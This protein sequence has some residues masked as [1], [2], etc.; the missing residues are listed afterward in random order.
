MGDTGIDDA[1]VGTLEFCIKIVGV[2]TP[3]AATYGPGFGRGL[4]CVILEGMGWT[5][6]KEKV[7]RLSVRIVEAQRP[8]RILDAIKWDASIEEVLRRGMTHPKLRAIPRVGR[9]YY[10]GRPL[11]FDPQKKIEEFEDISK[12]VSAVLGEKDELGRLLRTICEQYADTVRMLQSRGTPDFGHYSRKLYGSPK[13][14]LSGETLTV[15]E[16]GQWMHEILAG[17]GESMGEPYRKNLS[18]QQVVDELNRR[19]AGC[20]EGGQVQARISDE[21]LSDAAAGGDVIKIREG[22]LFSKREIDVYEV[23]EGWVHAGTSLNGRSQA[24]AQWLSR[25]PPRCAGT[26]EGLAVLLEIFT[27]RAHPRRARQINDRI[28]G[29][30]RAEDGADV[31]E[32]IE[33]YRTEGYSEEECLFNAIRIF[34]GGCV[35]G[36]APFTKDISYCKGFVENYNFMRAAIRAGHPELIPFLFVGKLSVEDVPL[37]Y[38]KH[39]EGLVDAPAFLPPPFADLSGVAVWMGF[40][41]FLNRVDLSRVQEH[42]NALFRQHL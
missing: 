25:G 2:H 4:G 27:F 40:S 14:R 5:T 20:F 11:M 30:D 17:L 3:L 23:H 26:Q 31:L 15:A 29:I 39:R 7:R 1:S 34:R 10:E 12:D 42:Y 24:V 22:A 38:R 8:I 6:L 37:L 41:S 21:I 16:L 36:G 13:D 32:L 18:A 9:D 33:F 19:F 28:L 35:E